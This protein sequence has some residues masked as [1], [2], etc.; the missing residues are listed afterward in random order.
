MDHAERAIEFSRLA[1]GGGVPP[2][3]YAELMFAAGEARAWAEALRLEH[4]G[5]RD[6]TVERLDGGGGW[7]E[8]RLYEAGAIE[9]RRIVSS[10]VTARAMVRVWCGDNRASI[11]QEPD[12]GE[13]DR[14][15]GDEG[16]PP[17][18]RS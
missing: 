3:R 8:V 12:L 2:S 13:F 9:R 18:A 14:L 17:W 4:R 15:F 1:Q 5:E 11:G 16:L 10:V 7:W 6:G